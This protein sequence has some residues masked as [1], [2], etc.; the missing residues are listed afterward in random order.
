MA[1]LKNKKLDCYMVAADEDT[2]REALKDLVYIANSS[3]SPPTPLMRKGFAAPW[4]CN[5]C[6]SVV[7]YTY[8][9]VYTLAAFG[10]C[11]VRV[12]LILALVYVCIGRCSIA[13]IF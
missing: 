11:W 8:S 5:L 9:F 3:H 6:T 2:I 4:A 10:E 13:Y 12:R 1:N 7:V